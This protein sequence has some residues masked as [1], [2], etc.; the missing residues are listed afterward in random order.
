MDLDQDSIKRLE[1]AITNLR[2][3]NFFRMHDSLWSLIYFS[4]IRGL[5]SGLGWVIGATIL[6][7]L[8]TVILSQIELIPILGEWA[9]SLIEQIEKFDK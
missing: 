6:V 4:L 3:H 1:K 8:L 7:Y 5:A 9:A 2:K